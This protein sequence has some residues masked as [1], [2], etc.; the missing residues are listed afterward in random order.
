MTRDGTLPMVNQSLD[1]YKAGLK[2]NFVE[3]NHFK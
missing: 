1:M 2:N 3:L